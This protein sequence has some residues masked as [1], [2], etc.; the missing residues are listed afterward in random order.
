MPVWSIVIAVLAALVWAVGVPV[1]VG[2]MHNFSTWSHSQPREPLSM[3]AWLVGREAHSPMAA[4]E[5]STGA[6]ARCIERRATTTWMNGTYEMFYEEVQFG[7]PF[8]SLYTASTG[9]RH[10]SGTPP[11]TQLAFVTLLD[12]RVGWRRGVIIGRG[13]GGWPKVIPVAPKWG[14]LANALLVALP[15]V[16]LVAGWRMLVARRWLEAERC[17]LCGYERAVAIGSCSECGWHAA[18]TSSEAQT[19]T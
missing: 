4:V 11:A 17:P 6:F 9:A 15:L 7:W 2:L 10:V 5:R 1:V 19:P 12:N 14:L 13:R 16:A 3:P 8:K 18:A